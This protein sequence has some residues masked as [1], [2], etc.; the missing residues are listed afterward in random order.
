M[1]GERADSLKASVKRA[2]PSQ[3]CLVKQVSL[4]VCLD[5]DILGLRRL[6]FI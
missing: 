4:A 2:L 3:K 6:L 1:D 5:P